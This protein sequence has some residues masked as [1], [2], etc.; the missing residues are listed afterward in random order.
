MEFILTFFVFPPIV[1]WFIIGILLMGVGLWSSTYNFNPL[2]SFISL[3]FVGFLFYVN[4]FD[5]HLQIWQIVAIL[6][7]YFPIGAIFSIFRWKRFVNKAAYD[8]IERIS[9]LKPKYQA[10]I[11]NYSGSKIPTFEEYIEASSF[12]RSTCLQPNDFKLQIYAWIAYWPICAIFYIFGDM[13]KEIAQRVAKELTKIY[14]KISS[15]EFDKVTKEL[16][17]M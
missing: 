3:F 12:R 8:E 2:L 6:I 16:R 11:A 4:K 9:E 13:V 7:L 17:K 1:F 5:L 15:D 10:Y 14:E